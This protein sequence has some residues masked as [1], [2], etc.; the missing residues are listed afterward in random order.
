VAAVFLRRASHATFD[1]DNERSYAM[2]RSKI[3]TA[4]AFTALTLAVL[5]STP[6]GQAAG[7]LV[8]GKSPVGTAQLK[9]NRDPGV[10]PRSKDRQRL[11]TGAPAGDVAGECHSVPVG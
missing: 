5:G 9:A 7:K 10:A 1:M 3:T 2:F 8:P 11:W 6:V 4:A